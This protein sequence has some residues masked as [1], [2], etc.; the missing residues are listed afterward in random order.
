MDNLPPELLLSILDYL[1]QDC[2]TPYGAMAIVNLARTCRGFWNVVEFWSL[3][4]ARQDLDSLSNLCA[5]DDSSPPSALSI[6]CRRLAHICIFCSN[7]GHYS[8]DE[9]FT[10]LPICRACEV[11]KVPKISN[12]SLDRLYFFRRDNPD[13]FLNTL[14]SRENLDHRLYLWRDI[15]PLIKNGDLIPYQITFYNRRK[16]A[17][18]LPIPYIPEE[19]G[20]FGFDRLYYGN[21]GGRWSPS[22]SEL[23]QNFLDDVMRSWNDPSF[24]KYSPILIEVSLF[25]E[26]HHRYDYSWQVKPTHEEQIAEYASVARHWTNKHWCQRPWHLS[27][28]PANP[29]YTASNPYA[30]QRHRDLD[31][32]AYSQHQKHCKLQRAVIRAFPEILTQPEVWCRCMEAS[33]LDEAVSLAASASLNHKPKKNRDL[34][35]ELVTSL[36]HGKDVHLTRTARKKDLKPVMYMTCDRDDISLRKVAIVRIRNHSVLIKRPG[37]GAPRK[38]LGLSRL[39]ER[40]FAME[41]SAL[42]YPKS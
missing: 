9:K 16:R 31:E 7:R 21:E 22:K 24:D 17:R 33:Q 25:N 4:E 20:E 2:K 8:V 23:R 5:K 11:R 39:R 38:R 32:E 34:D 26:F 40:G 1:R 19:H 30:Q 18:I 29:R 41:K 3:K 10:N 37:R 14:E 6:L 36:E 13:D 27:A 35:F 28:F 42:S 15:E 12:I